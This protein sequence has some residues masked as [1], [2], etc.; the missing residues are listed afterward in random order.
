MRYARYHFE[1]E[2][3]SRTRRIVAVTIV[4][5]AVL[6][7][8][9]VTSGAI[10]ALAAS[11]LQRVQSG[12]TAVAES[13]LGTGFFESRI[14]LAEENAELKA[15]I[16]KYQ[17][18]A[19]SAS[20]LSAQ[21]AELAKL[22][23][24]SQ[25]RPGVTA[26]IA[27]RESSMGTFFVAAGEREGVAAGDLVLTDDGFVI[28]IVSE[29][30]QTSSLCTDIF[31]PGST[32]DALIGSTRVSLEGKGGSNAR[33]K[34]ERTASIAAGDVATAASVSGYPIGVV[35]HVESGAT[36]AYQEVYVRSSRT[37]DTTR[38]VYIERP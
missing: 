15:Q 10:R 6:L 21:N 30:Q 7:A 31:A 14:K 35:G 23:H 9:V 28:A 36:D 5:A 11:F 38:F 24:L 2:H 13:V 12:A 37:V 16:E 17:S 25:V 4:A 20:A 18:L 29:V 34:A 27:S 19:L 1:P 3:R 8:D 26:A 32:I 22:A 33:G